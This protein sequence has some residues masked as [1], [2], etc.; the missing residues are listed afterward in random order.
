[1]NITLRQLRAFLAVAELGRFNL[2]ANHLGLTQSAVSILIRE[3]E[4]EM[5]VRLFDRHTRMVSVSV[6]GQEFLP[7]ARKVLE[8]LDQATRSVRDSAAL[9]SGQVTIAAAIVLAA[10]IVP[11]L[12]AEFLRLHPGVTVQLRDMPEERI[13]LALKRNEVDLAIG[14]QVDEDPELTSTPVTHDRLMLICHADHPL[15]RQR[16]VRWADLEGERM[17]VLA[18]ENPLREIVVRTMIQVV[19]DFRPSYEVRFSS[20]AISMISAGMGVSVLPENS[21]LLTSD[22]RVRSVG[23]V[24]PDI[25]REVGL[26]QH[27]YRSLSPAASLLREMILQRFAAQ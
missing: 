25:G 12:L 11:P 2:A 4:S 19:P 17:I 24:E 3:L 1:M 20:T 26:L 21:R 14:T 8:D 27:R 15:A 9:K 6:M 18:Q 22:V 13:R 16:K 23:L 7:Q 5:G 10:T